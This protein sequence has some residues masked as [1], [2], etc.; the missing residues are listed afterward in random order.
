MRKAFLL[1]MGLILIGG[2]GPNQEE[3]RT[4]AEKQQALSDSTF[5]PMAESMDRAREVEQLQ[6]DRKDRIDAALE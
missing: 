6:L 3:V 4:E 1:S 5:G 2:C